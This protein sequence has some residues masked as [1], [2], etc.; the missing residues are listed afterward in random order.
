MDQESGEKHW[1]C[2]QHNMFQFNQIEPKIMFIRKPLIHSTKP[3]I[4]KTGKISRDT[5]KSLQSICTLLKFPEAD[6]TPT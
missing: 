1:L 6:L 4:Q 3:M 5:S 2:I